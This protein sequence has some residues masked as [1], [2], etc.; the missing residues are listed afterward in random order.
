MVDQVKAI[1]FIIVS[2]MVIIVNVIEICILVRKRRHLTNYERLLLSLS[3]ADFLVGLTFLVSQ[4]VRFERINQNIVGWVV[5]WYSITTSLFHIVLLTID[6]AI[7]VVYPLKHRMW[8]TTKFMKI[9]IGA[10]WLSSLAILTIL[11]F[12]TTRQI[13]KTVLGYLINMTIWILVIVY[14]VIIY[15]AVIKRHRS[16]QLNSSASSFSRRDLN[17]V[18]ISILIAATFTAFTMPFAIKSMTHQRESFV[19]TL[20]IVLNSFTNPTIYFFWTFLQRCTKPTRVNTNAANA[21]SLD[22]KM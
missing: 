18:I 16:R 9:S 15:K 19:D 21:E 12:N 7:A 3:A 10:I 20:I 4:A 5:F 13:S 2:S 1:T 8:I 22:T 14:S 6:R 17:L 11:T